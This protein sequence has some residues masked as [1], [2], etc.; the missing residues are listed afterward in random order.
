MSDRTDDPGKAEGGEPERGGTAAPPERVARN[1]FTYPL[2]AI[3]GALVGAGILAFVVMVGIDLLGG[4]DNPYRAIVTWIGIP[5]VI[6]V[7]AALTAIGAIRVARQA[8]KRGE[9][10]RFMLRIEPSNPRY[11]RNL[12]LF[13]GSMAVLLVLVVYS[14]IRA[15]EATESVSFCGTACHEVMGP[16]NT[17]YLASAHARVPCVE[18]HIGPGRSVW[19]KSKLDGLRQ[20]WK[21]FTNSFERPIPT[22]VTA[23]RPAQETCEHCHWPEQ[24]YGQTL[25]N[26][27]YFRTDEANSPWTITLLVNVGGGNPRT[28]HLEGIHWHM[29][30]ANTIEYV[31]ADVQRQEIPW[32]RATDLD[33]NVTVYDDP[34]S[35]I[36]PDSEGYEVRTFDC[37]DCH[38]RPSHKF[39]PP[40]TA[41]NLEISRG[42]IDADLPYIRKVGL[43]LLNARYETTDEAL[44]AIPGGL[45]EFYAAEYPD[46]IEALRAQIDEAAA[47]LQDI[48][49]GNFFPE[50][51]TDYRVRVNNLSHFTNDGC[52]RCHNDDLVSPEGTTI[53]NACDTCHSIVAQGPS[54]DVTSLETDLNGLEFEHPVDIAGV[55]DRIR[56]TQCHNPAQGY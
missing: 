45:S 42:T 25:T 47:T 6:T 17:T 56:C 24:F 54:D 41:I 21:T 9:R 31:A 4:A 36:G 52:F 40:A 48:Y 51:E 29:V 30:T 53:A 18:C 34:E 33:G 32:V 55:W 7:G 20:V 8:R 37:I 12:W 44:A 50:M 1:L 10:I 27:S 39:Q 35:D 23:L 19:V 13:L 22:P 5:F 26:I 2:T 49:A 16:Q 43:D 15:Y 28:G 3:G 11:M 38:N 14:G 46:D